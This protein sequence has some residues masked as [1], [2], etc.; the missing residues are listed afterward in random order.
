MSFDSPLVEDDLMIA[1]DSGQS[2][3]K[4]GVCLSKDDGAHNLKSATQG[5]GP[6]SSVDRFHLD[7]R[8]QW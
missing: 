5:F 4:I 7:S 6:F 3:E 2:T 1:R 8:A